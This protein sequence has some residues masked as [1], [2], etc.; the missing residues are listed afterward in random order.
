MSEIRNKEKAIQIIGQNAFY[1]WY[2][3]NGLDCESFQVVE[4]LYNF[5]ER[6]LNNFKK[7]Y[8]F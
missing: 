6:K 3:N 7:K 5:T 1:G 4:A 2:Y 8:G